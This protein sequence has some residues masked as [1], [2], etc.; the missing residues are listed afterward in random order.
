M[1]RVVVVQLA[2]SFRHVDRQIKLHVHSTINVVQKRILVIFEK[3]EHFNIA[4][5]VQPAH[6]LKGLLIV[7][8]FN[9]VE[10][11]LAQQ[12]LDATALRT[13]NTHLQWALKVVP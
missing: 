9:Y 2:V 11:A 6:D 8:Q 7:S 13:V 1:I 4:N 12:S 5:V 10:F 3:F